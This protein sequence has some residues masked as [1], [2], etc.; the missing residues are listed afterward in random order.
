MYFVYQGCCKA[1]DVASE[2]VVFQMGPGAAFGES[3]LVLDVLEA[4]TAVADFK[5][6]DGAVPLTLLI[7]LDRAIALRLRDEF[8]SWAS[9]L[10]RE[11]RRKISELME[12]LE[13]GEIRQRFDAIAEQEVKSARGNGTSISFLGF[14]LLLHQLS[15]KFSMHDA[16]QLFDSYD[17]DGSDSISFDEFIDSCRADSAKKQL[18]IACTT[19]QASVRFKKQAAGRGQMAPNSGDPSEP[20][21]AERAAEGLGIHTDTR[22]SAQRTL[23]ERAYKASVGIYI[24]KSSAS[25]AVQAG[26][27][28]GSSA[29]LPLLETERLSEAE[30]RRFRRSYNGQTDTCRTAGNRQT[31]RRGPRQPS[32]SM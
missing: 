7:G 2:K 16:R 17:E 6:I 3:G 13:I 12:R 14:R 31:R 10:E 18:A 22:T 8:P 1:I 26:D 23:A 21:S 19:A 30:V 11:R 9:A 24:M 28:A 25:A 27:G 32:Q 4:Y 20:S 5:P 15:I 29:G